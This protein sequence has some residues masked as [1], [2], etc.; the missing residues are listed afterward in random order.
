V[1][2]KQIQLL[3]FLKELGRPE[4]SRGSFHSPALFDARATRSVR[5]PLDSSSR[6]G[7]LFTGLRRAIQLYRSRVQGRL[8]GPTEERRKQLSKLRRRIQVQGSDGS[9]SQEPVEQVQLLKIV[10]AS[11][12]LCPYSIKLPRPLLGQILE[13]CPRTT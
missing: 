6:K 12:K 11:F 13:L 10:F 1:F 5:E 3:R 2:K 7:H 9:G 4:G 8:K